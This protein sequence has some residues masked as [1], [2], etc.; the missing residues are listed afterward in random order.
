MKERERRQRKAEP[1]AAADAVARVLDGY[2]L[3][4]PVRHARLALEWSRIVGS[5]IGA[6]TQPGML[7]SGILHLRVSNSSWLHQLSFLRADIIT[8]INSALG[9]PP[10]VHDLRFHLGGARYAT[11]APAK[12]GPTAVRREPLRPVPR[13]TP[14]SG[15]DLR[16]I[17]AESAAIDDPELR[18]IVT[19]AR[20]LVNR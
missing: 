7:D 5:R 14:A 15:D 20:R 16:A 11:P 1:I 17:E 10:L 12:P 9:D 6:R 4:E 19:E 8:A 13:P 3:T 2:H 18:A